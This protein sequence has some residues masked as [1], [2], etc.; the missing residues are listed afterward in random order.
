M[1]TA[2]G[3]QTI[4][5]MLD[6]NNELCIYMILI[7]ASI[8]EWILL[9]IL[10]V[11][12]ICSRRRIHRCKTRFSCE[13]YLSTS[14]YRSFTPLKN[15]V[16]NIN[17]ALAFEIHTLPRRALQDASN[18]HTWEAS[19][20]NFRQ[21]DKILSHLVAMDREPMSTRFGCGTSCTIK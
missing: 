11:Y 4:K 19:G 16:V 13:K 17:K 2:T 7:I 3:P 10:M 15:H 18:P 20:K 21:D 9:H 1:M 12:S 6:W 8:N 14:I 5:A